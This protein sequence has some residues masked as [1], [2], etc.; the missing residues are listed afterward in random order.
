MVWCGVGEIGLFANMKALKAEQRRSETMAERR[1]VGGV[2]NDSKSTMQKLFQLVL[3]VALND[4]RLVA[5]K[6]RTDRALVGHTLRRVSGGERVQRVR[7]MQLLAM[8]RVQ[9]ALDFFRVHKRKEKSK[10]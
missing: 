1:Y 5:Q 8:V 10:H 6:L 9:N 3:A 2:R 7:V 4:D